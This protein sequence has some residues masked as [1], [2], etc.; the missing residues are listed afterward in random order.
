MNSNKNAKTN[1]NYTSYNYEKK[2][3]LTNNSIKNKEKSLK[4]NK[5]NQKEKIVKKN[6]NVNLNIYKISPSS[7]TQKYITNSILSANKAITISGIKQYNESKYGS[8]K[9]VKKQKTIDKKLRQRS[10]INNNININININSNNIYNSTNHIK[11]NSNNISNTN[12]NITNNNI[13]NNSI[14]NK[15]DLIKQYNDKNILRNESHPM[16]KKILLTSSSNRNVFKKNFIFEELNKKKINAN[17]N[18]N[19]ITFSGCLTSRSSNNNSNIKNTIKNSAENGGKIKNINSN[20]KYKKDL[21]IKKEV[22]IK[23]K[24]LSLKNKTGNIQ[25]KY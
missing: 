10:D 20:N 16:L 5:T 18:N 2:K 6:K 24:I 12:N 13:P 23:N 3:I 17:I 19:T 1:Y 25:K 8:I 21:N 22:I 9:V 11:Y 14:N 7:I 4:Q 15:K